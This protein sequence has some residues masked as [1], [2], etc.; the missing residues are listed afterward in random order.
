MRV[1][2]LSYL[3]LGLVALLLVSVQ[4][5]RA[6]GGKLTVHATPRE[7]Y[8]YADGKPVA[9]ARGHTVTLPA[10]EHKIDL[11]NYGYKPETR[12]VTI[13]AHK[14]AVIEVTMQAIAGPF[15]GRG[16]V[17]RSKAPRGLRCC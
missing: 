6:Q 12:N 4:P 7:A 1:R 15:P 2:P 9:E 3:L 5:V 8:I 17:S 14:T 16:V 13:E 10:G 11:Y